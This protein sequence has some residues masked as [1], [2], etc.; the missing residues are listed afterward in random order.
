MGYTAAHLNGQI[1]VALLLKLLQSEVGQGSTPLGLPLGHH[2]PR[3]SLR[4]ART[5]TTEVLRGN[6]TVCDS[7]VVVGC[8]LV[9]S[10]MS[11]Q[12]VPSMPTAVAAAAHRRLL[13]EHTLEL[14][15]SPV[16]ECW[17]C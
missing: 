12:D 6:S 14:Q 4:S 7:L 10:A 1:E 11:G 5:C 3:R 15:V 16:A 17:D 13:L 9:L 8:A 2:R